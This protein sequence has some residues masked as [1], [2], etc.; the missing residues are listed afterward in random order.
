[1]QRL[2]KD[3][4]LVPLTWRG[5]SLQIC[6]P[7]RLRRAVGWV[8]P[9][10]VKVRREGQEIVLSAYDPPP[11]PKSTQPAWLERIEELVPE[12]KP[13]GGLGGILPVKAL[14]HPKRKR[15]S[16]KPPTIY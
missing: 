16:R 3:T 1:M 13:Q 2:D 15:N 4:Y 10:V 9:V 7:I 5:E 12:L 8:A 14:F 11:R 6:L